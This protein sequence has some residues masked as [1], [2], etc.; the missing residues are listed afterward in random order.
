VAIAVQLVNYESHL[1]N[2]LFGFASFLEKLGMFFT[3]LTRRL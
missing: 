1:R 2:M 3:V